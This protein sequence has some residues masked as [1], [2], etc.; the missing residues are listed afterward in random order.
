MPPG[1]APPR[2]HRRLLLVVLGVSL[3]LRVLLVFEGGQRY[4]PDE[5]RYERSRKAVQAWRHGSGAAAPRALAHPDHFLF[6][7]L[8]LAPAAVELATGPDDRVP[9]LF[10]SLFSV[11]SIGL[12]WSI[13][14]RLGES[15][16]SALVAALLLGASASQ[17]YG[18]RHL[19]PYDA[20][21]AL[22]LAALLVASRPGPSP[23]GSALCG[24]LAAA[25]LLTYNGYWLL[26]GTALAIHALGAPT[27]RLAA[28]RA[29]VAGTAFALP[30]AAL[31]AA[32]AFVG[33]GAFRRGWTAFA[34]TVTQGDFAEGWR[35]PFAYLWHAEHLLTLLW[36]AAFVFA[37]VRLAR[38]DRSRVFAFGLAGI[39]LIYGGLVVGSV[40]LERFVV[41]GRQARQLVPFACLLSAAALER[42]AGARHRT[43]ALAAAILVAVLAQAAA[44][45]RTPLVQV[46]PREFRRMAEKI[47]NPTGAPRLLLYAEHIYPAPAPPPRD[48]G[49]VLLA[50]P[51]PL[52]FLPYQYEGYTPRERAA[53]RAADIRMRLVEVRARN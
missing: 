23:L 14:R 18:S 36:A 5:V 47:P 53:L 40:A 11:A 39:L 30:I 6:G 9:A 48:A 31:T 43:G 17:L 26:A 8:G 44:N 22:G 33:G 52:Q 7:I 35:L 49:T 4:W 3:A 2:D 12:L 16:R 34:R 20:A 46:F 29:A 37:A 51:H 27:L 42:L 41:Y 45:F 1:A 21:M 32:D 38:G 50:R 13:A 10:F 25:T 24:L 15:E 28:R 19:L